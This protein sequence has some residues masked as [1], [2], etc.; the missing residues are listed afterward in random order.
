MSVENLSPRALDFLRRNTFML[1]LSGAFVISM[2]MGLR[3]SFGLFMGPMTQDLGIDRETFGFAMAMQNLLWGAFQ[4]FCGMVADRYGSGKV[5][6]VGTVAYA[7]GLYVMSGAETVLGFNIGAGWLIGFGLSATSFSVVLGAL[8]RLV[9]VEKQSVAFGIATAGGSVG[10]FVM[11]PIGQ[12]LI[13][14]QGWAPA[15][16]VLGWLA[17]TMALG[18]FILQSKA[19]D[20]RKSGVD[21]STGAE[22]TL[23][24]ALAEASTNRGYIYL[25][26]GFF[27]CGF[28]V[29]FITIHMPSYISDLGLNASVAATS[30]ALIGLFNIVGTYACGVMGGKYSKKYL[31]SALY[32]LRAVVVLVFVA[33]PKSELS[34]YLFA[35]T[36]GLLWLGTVPLTSGLVA[37]IFGVRY[38][39]TLFGIVFLSHQVGSFLGVWLGGYLYETTGSYDG[40]WYGSIVL[41]VLAALIHLPITERPVARLATNTV[42]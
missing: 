27:V 41:G 15:L 37:Q 13:D 29:A 39:S 40:V 32:F 33:L 8:S 28:Q 10:Q 23:R 6:L 25:T 30:L 11:A 35:G 5:L 19:G 34:V 26:L 12:H 38:M 42:S 4:P 1:V 18:A 2:T 31:L 24:A 9:P 3:S 36:M 16:T 14:T 17:L 22:Q 21:K 20:E 7:A